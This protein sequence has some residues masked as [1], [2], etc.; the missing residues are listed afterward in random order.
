MV[1]LQSG[2]ACRTLTCR[3]ESITPI[4]SVSRRPNHPPFHPHAFLLPSALPPSAPFC[5]SFLVS[6]RLKV[7]LSSRFHSE[8]AL[9]L[10]TTSAIRQVQKESRRL[11]LYQLQV[12]GW[13]GAAGVKMTGACAL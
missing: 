6:C 1:S 2:D 10:A 3:V 12:P 5:P 8:R 9:A 11:D 7:V 4:L 13:G